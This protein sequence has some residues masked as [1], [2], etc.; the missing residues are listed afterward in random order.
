[1]GHRVEG[2]F[3]VAARGGRGE[4]LRHVLTVDKVYNL[5]CEILGRH[6]QIDSWEMNKVKL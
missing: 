4:G 3:S 1:M 2:K 5:V 6:L